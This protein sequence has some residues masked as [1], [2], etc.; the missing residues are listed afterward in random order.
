MLGKRIV[1]IV[2]VALI[3]TA[4]S[5]AIVLAEANDNN[6][7][8][9]LSDKKLSLLAQQM[10]SS[11][12]TEKQKKD[13]SAT[14]ASLKPDQVIRLKKIWRTMLVSKGTITEKESLAFLAL[15]KIEIIFS[16]KIKELY[17]EDATIYSISSSELFVVETALSD[18]VAL[19]ELTY[20]VENTLATASSKS[21]QISMASGCYYDPNW[22]QWL[23]AVSEPG[24]YYSGGGSGRVANDGPNE[25]PCD[26][27]IYIPANTYTKVTG[28]NVDAQ[29][30]VD[31]GGGLSAS[32]SKDAAIVGYGRVA[33]F[34]WPTEY[35]VRNNILFKP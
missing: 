29:N 24:T 13:V 5:A 32:P 9:F 11:F 18:D 28:A 23:T 1:G 8:V 27:V 31:W 12:L 35:W 14:L 34:G 10:D 4:I 17:G 26:F 19:K 3:V 15:E 21:A 22:P 7:K 20:S 33:L 30:V 25:W 16:Q 6:Q 2:V